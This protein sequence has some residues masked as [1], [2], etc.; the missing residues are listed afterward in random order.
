MSET[1]LR[2]EKFSVY[3]NSNKKEDIDMDPRKLFL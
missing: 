3:C 2:A 1:I